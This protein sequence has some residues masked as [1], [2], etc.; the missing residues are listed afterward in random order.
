MQV[1]LITTAL[2]VLL[3][4][5]L[6]YYTSKAACEANKPVGTLCTE[7]YVSTLGTNYIECNR[8]QGGLCAI[9]DG[10]LYPTVAACLQSASRQYSEGVKGDCYAVVQK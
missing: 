9:R 4:N 8:W 3:T 10:S 2:G 1:F 7:H 6:G 5:P